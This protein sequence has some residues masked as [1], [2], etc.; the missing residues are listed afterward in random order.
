MKLY[1]VPLRPKN[2]SVTPASKRTFEFSGPRETSTIKRPL[3]HS[4]TFSSPSTVKKVSV[5]TNRSNN[6]FCT[7]S[8][9][10]KIDFK[11]NNRHT[12]AADDL[13]VS[14]IENVRNNKFPRES[15]DLGNHSIDSNFS[16]NASTSTVVDGPF[17]TISYS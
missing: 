17:P 12:V 9:I 13:G 3:F 8:K 10:R 5:V 15:T 14:R 4:N 6:T 2:L 11:Q 1:T 7:P 16:L